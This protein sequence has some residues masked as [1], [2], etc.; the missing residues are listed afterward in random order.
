MQ[1]RPDG[2]M[3]NSHDQEA[4]KPRETNPLHHPAGLRRLTSQTPHYSRSTPTRKTRQ[5]PTQVSERRRI[6]FPLPHHVPSL[7]PR[8]RTILLHLACPHPAPLRVQLQQHPT[9]TFLRLNH[10]RLPRQ[11]RTTQT[12]YQQTPTPRVYK[13]QHAP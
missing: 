10:H 6:N 12:A 7:R 4:L 13:V 3:F 5:D 1:T 8:R 2:G 9:E 11:H